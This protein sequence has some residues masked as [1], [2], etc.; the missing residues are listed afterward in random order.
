MNKFQKL[1]MYAKQKSYQFA[2]GAAVAVASSNASAAIDVTAVT[3]KLAEGEAA[4]G[5]IGAAVLTVWAIRKVYSM[6]RG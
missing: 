5:L 6:I 4:V 3:A 2:V 1:A